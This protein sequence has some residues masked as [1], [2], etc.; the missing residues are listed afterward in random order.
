MEPAAGL[1]VSEQPLLSSSPDDPL[2]RA[3]TVGSSLERNS[4]NVIATMSAERQGTPLEPVA[5]GQVSIYCIYSSNPS[6]LLPNSTRWFK[7]G[8]PLDGV[9]SSASRLN[10]EQNEPSV[11]DQD[12]TVKLSSSGGSQ[13]LLESFTAT[14]YPV[15]TINQVNRRDA[16][17]YDCQVSNSIGQSERLPTSESCKLEV[18]FRPRAQLRLFRVTAPKS[19]QP[20]GVD[21]QP[22]E[23]V[24]V[25]VNQELVMPGGL[26]V[27]VCSVLEAQPNIIDKFHWFRRDLAGRVGQRLAGQQQLMNKTE[28]GQLSLGPLAANFI[29]SS[30]ACSASN[31]LGPGEQSDKIELQ[32]S[33]APSKF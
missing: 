22:D 9:V 10:E 3:Q 6:Q 13:H 5:S 7:D 28:S 29:A 24:E 20:P 18:N 14:G 26:F 31:S 23:L 19:E 8:Q 4:D 33:Y 2:Q 25:D 32:L 15:L 16:G 17:L 1:V 21:Y 27:L 12:E 11:F 30:F